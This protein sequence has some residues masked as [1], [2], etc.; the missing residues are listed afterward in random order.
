MRK[1]LHIIDWYDLKGN[2]EISDTWECRSLIKWRVTMLKWHIDKQG[3]KQ[4]RLH[5]NWRNRI[6]RC[7]RLVATAFITNPEDKK[8]INHKNWI[9]DDNRV[10]NLEWTTSAENNKHAYEI[11]LKE[12]YWKWIKGKNHHS[13]MK[14]NQYDM[15]LNFIKTWDCIREA[16]E[17]VK[18]SSWWIS[19]VCKWKWISSWWF[20]REYA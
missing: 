5:T 4:Y 3:Y 13:S 8:I 1:R 15:N 12:S 20:K 10:D 14:V 7:H 9:K 6:F 11:W 17:F 19:R 16:E 18:V 2:Y